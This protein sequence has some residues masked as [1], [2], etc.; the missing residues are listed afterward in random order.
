MKISD[1][2]TVQEAAALKGVAEQSIRNALKRG[3]FPGAVKEGSEYRGT[4]YLPRAEVEAWQP[5]KYP[6]NR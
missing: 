5:R 2:L 4:W 3:A 6:R 1:Y